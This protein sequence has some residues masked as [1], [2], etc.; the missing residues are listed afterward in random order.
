MPWYSQVE[1]LH[2]PAMY[3]P[4]LPGDGDLPKVC[5]RQGSLPAQAREIERREGL[6]GEVW[7]PQ[8]RMQVTFH[9]KLSWKARC[10]VKGAVNALL[11]SYE[12]LTAILHFLFSIA[13]KTRQPSRSRAIFTAARSVFISVQR[14]HVSSRR[15]PVRACGSA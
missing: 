10:R 3:G 8:G 9:L 1:I 7:R 4:S 13:T 14:F 5:Q 12:I 15:Q 2:P 11:S 6:A